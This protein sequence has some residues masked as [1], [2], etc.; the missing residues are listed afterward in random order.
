MSALEECGRYWQELGGVWGGTNRDPIHFEFPGFREDLQ[1]GT[2]GNPTDLESPPTGVVADI[3]RSIGPGP[4]WTGVIPG[5]PS[6]VDILNK[7]ASA[8]ERV[9]L[10]DLAYKL[11]FHEEK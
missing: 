3:G 9:G 2:I 8:V 1:A 6:Y 7:G 11:F 4:W 5:F 10:V